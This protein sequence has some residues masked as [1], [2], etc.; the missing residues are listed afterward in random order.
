[1][2]MDRSDCIELMTEPPWRA[3]YGTKAMSRLVAAVIGVLTAPV[4]VFFALLVKL[5]SDGPVVYRQVRTGQF[6]RPFTLYKIRTMYSNAEKDTGPTWCRDGDNRVTPLGRF[7]RLTHIDELPQLYNV[8]RGE[9]ALVGP[10]P[11]RPEIVS[12]LEVAIP[13]Y[14]ERL[15]VL[16][17]LTGLAQVTLPPDTSLMSVY[18]KLQLD[19][20][21][22]ENAG[23]WVDVSIIL[24]TFLLVLGV[25][26]TRANDDLTD[27]EWVALTAL[28]GEGGQDTIARAR[29]PISPEN[30]DFFTRHG[31]ALE[32][33]RSAAAR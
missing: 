33:S 21:Y 1:M 25:R 20:A 16:P 29:S 8:L 27:G 22:V 4:L 2:V 3:G 28:P 14:G 15:Q 24:R 12:E 11:E 23:V 32:S 18:H 5:T 30:A 31:G 19:L 13:R 6:G 7:L 10:R 17:G 26:A 9:M